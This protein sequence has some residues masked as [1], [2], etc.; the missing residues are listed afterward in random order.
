VIPLV[1]GGKEVT[2]S[3]DGLTVLVD[4]FTWEF[5]S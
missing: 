2:V 3:K 5:V 4:G 1:I